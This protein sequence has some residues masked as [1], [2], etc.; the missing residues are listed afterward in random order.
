MSNN[1]FL[2]GYT[3]HIIR[4]HAIEYGCEAIWATVN[5]G[6]E[7]VPCALLKHACL[8]QFYRRLSQLA[9]GR[10]DYPEAIKK[11]WHLWL[12]AQLIA[13]MI[14]K[15]GL[16]WAI[17][18]VLDFLKQETPVYDDVGLFDGSQ[19]LINSSTS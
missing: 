5:E 10:I 2:P 19:I 15:A 7:S 11:S 1:R 16:S 13:P 17:D 8:D 18:Y 9:K 12:C 3:N 14:L 6:V 4:D